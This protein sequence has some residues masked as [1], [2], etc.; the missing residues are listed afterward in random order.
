MTTTQAAVPASPVDSLADRFWE[1]VLELSPVTATIYGD[2]RYDDRLDDPGPAGRGRLRELCT[3]TL[4]EVRAL[5]GSASSL[6]DRITLDMLRVVCE[7]N[8]EQLDQ[9]ID[10]L[11]VVDQMEGP[12]TTLPVVAA[13]QRVDSPD[14]VDRF[15]ARVRAYEGYM[16][17]NADLVREGLATGLT[18]PRILVERMIA[19]LERV[20]ATPAEESP[21]VTSP[22]GL[23]DADRERLA[24]LV[25]DVVR[26]ADAAFLEALRGDYLSAAREEPGLWSAPD[27][28][29]L[30]RTAIRS[31]TSLDLDPAEVHRIGLEE[32]AA[33]DEERRAISRSMGF[34]DDVATARATVLAD[35]AGIPETPEALVAKA[36]AHVE[37]AKAAAPRVFG[38]LPRAACEVRRVEP[39]K[40]A[41][42]PFA[43]Y[44]PP[45]AD[46]SRPGT[47]WVNAYDLPSRHFAKLA[48]TSFH[49]AIPGHHFQIT[50]EIEHPALNRFRRLGSRMVG[51]AYSEGWGLYCERLADELGLYE[52][53]GERLGMLDAQAWRAARL[54]VDTGIHALRWTRRQGVEQMLV[55]GL[56][57]TDAEIETNRYIAWPAQ[58]LTYKI[59]QREIERLRREL[60]ARDGDSFDLRA[61]HDAVLAHGSV[62]LATLA[63][64]LP[65]WLPPAA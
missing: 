27:G 60:T 15:L 31:W 1:G 16:A 7:N 40:E 22:R 57:A 11:R 41:D 34:G 50:L 59:G 38:R 53:E 13:I 45:A 62:P 48:S 37:R 19:Q 9:R 35:P 43:Y 8:L 65:S 2:E 46:G 32:L 4:A 39:Y 24:G 61:F 23:G 25:R 14:R 58:A 3:G 49:E 26:P 12:Q 10:R 6:E 20:L 29:Q 56:S 28:E 42:A 52:T 18:A 47:Y 51:T 44:L 30:Y 36:Q 64:G 5:G 33:I 17:A 54:I 63:A 21:V 55:A